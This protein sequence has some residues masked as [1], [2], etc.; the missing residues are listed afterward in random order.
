MGAR[1]GRLSGLGA[2]RCPHEGGARSGR[3]GGRGEEEGA[4]PELWGSA[5][6]RPARSWRRR[7][8][9]FTAAW[10]AGARRAEGGQAPGGRGAGGEE[11]GSETRAGSRAPCPHLGEQDTLKGPRRFSRARSGV[12]GSR[13]G[14]QRSR[15]GGFWGSRLPELTGRSAPPPSERL[16]SELSRG[17]RGGES[18]VGVEGLK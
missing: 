12:P 4:V 15:G 8:T 13:P 2:P 17:W 14:R 6:R 10:L 9:W 1:G 16:T 3:R 11:G 5:A 7:R 18:G